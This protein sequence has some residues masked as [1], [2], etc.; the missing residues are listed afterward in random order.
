MCLH[1]TIADCQPESG[2]GRFC[3]PE[4]FEKVLRGIFIY[5]GAVI[6]DADAGGVS[7]D[8]VFNQYF[9][10]TRHCIGGILQQ[11]EEDLMQLARISGNFS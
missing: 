3:C 1:N 2:S 10:S 7:G 4:W 5:P 9:A 8:F 11:I 6:A